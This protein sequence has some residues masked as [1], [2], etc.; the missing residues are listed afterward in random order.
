MKT[1]SYF[2]V[3]LL[4]SMIFNSCSKDDIIYSCDTTVNSWVKDNIAQ[5]QQMT[6]ADWLRTNKELG[7]PTYRAFTPEQKERFWKE[8]FEEVK[9][10]S[11]TPKELK[12][13]HKVEQFIADHPYIFSGNPLTDSQLD[14]LD[15][16][17]YQWQN[18]AIQKLNW[19]PEVGIAIAGTGN[20]MKNTKGEVVLLSSKRIEKMSTRAESSCNCNTG[21]ISD[22]CFGAPGPC[23]NSF[24]SSRSIGC[25]WLLA[26]SCNG[27]CGGI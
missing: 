26:Q 17:F 10:L 5:I 23:E 6:R 24:C 7:I 14:E 15:L 4:S 20:A 12:H 13:I 19:R 25:G 8:K 11:W 3:L 16:F 21:L 18:E 2:L 1:I 9:Q 27:L 22:F